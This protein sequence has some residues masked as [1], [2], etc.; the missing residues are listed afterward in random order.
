VSGRNTSHTGPH[1]LTHPELQSLEAMLD[2]IERARDFAIV[3][4]KATRERSIVLTKLDEA[5]LWARRAAELGA[6]SL[7]E[8]P[9]P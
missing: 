9:T 4:M 8:E 7:G 1:P 2:V 6:C 3:S 5:A